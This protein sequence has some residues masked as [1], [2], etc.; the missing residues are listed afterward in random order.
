MSSR[1]EEVGFVSIRDG[2]VTGGRA[3]VDAIVNVCR[4]VMEGIFLYWIF[5]LYVHKLE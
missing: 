1:S 3:L 5:A 2:D 4:V